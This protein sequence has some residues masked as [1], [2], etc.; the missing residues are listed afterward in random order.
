MRI[1]ALALAGGCVAPTLDVPDEPQ[2]AVC[3]REVLPIGATNVEVAATPLGATMV[4]P[5]PAGVMAQRLDRDARAVGEAVL[6]WPGVYERATIA[7]IGDQVIVGAVTAELTWM[8]SAPLG[9]P[10]YRELAILGGVVGAS[11]IVTAQSHRLAASV[12]YG[13]MQVNAFDATWTPQTALQAVL[14]GDSHEVAAA[15]GDRALV[16]WPTQ[17]ACNIA[18]LDD[19]ATGESSKQPGRCGAPRLAA[20]TLA[21]E[22]DGGI[23]VTHELS[24]AI[25]LRI[26][27]GRA[28]R[29]AAFGERTWL[30]YI[31]ASGTLVAGF[32]DQRP[33]EAGAC[34]QLVAVGPA[35]AHE[36]AIIGGVP[37]VF[38]ASAGALTVSSLC[39]E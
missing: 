39:A 13:G 9:I 22:R 18:W 25:A 10:P 37:R 23:Y 19:A 38:A 26:G 7:A 14:T 30:S 11:P 28:P 34:D 17:D 27:D 15:S 5:T 29:I 1:L 8:M 3:A 21:F 4:W 36:L 6:I 2:P 24:P 33:C 20:T 31:D 35:D 32:G 16:V 12:S